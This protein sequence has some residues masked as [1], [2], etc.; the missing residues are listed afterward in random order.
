MPVEGNG[1]R[2]NLADSWQP[3]G[4]QPTSSPFH[5][6]RPAAP[7]SRLDPR[8]FSKYCTGIPFF[9]HQPPTIFPPSTSIPRHHSSEAPCRTVSS[10]LLA[11]ALWP[12]CPGSGLPGTV[13]R[14]SR[15]C[16]AITIPFLVY[17]SSPMLAQFSPSATSQTSTRRAK[18]LMDNLLPL[19]M[20][21]SR[22]DRDAL[23]PASRR[24]TPRSPST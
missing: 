16:N 3:A 10:R 5:N 13:E 12:T 7:V 6:F 20:M 18:S 22:A 19:A 2:S 9:V 17:Y 21:T 15:K 24:T 14:S 4:R 23:I 11:M 1:A 8:T